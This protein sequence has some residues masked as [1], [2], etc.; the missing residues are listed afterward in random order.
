MSWADSNADHRFNFG[1]DMGTL[2]VMVKDS[3]GS[4]Q[5]IVFSDPSIFTNTMYIQPENGNNR[6]FIRNLTANN[7]PL[8]ID[9]MNSRTADAKGL[10]GIL[11]VVR[12]TEIIEIIIF[13]LLMLAAAW[14]W[15]KKA[16]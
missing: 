2:P 15:K 9:Q 12:N 16:I 13:C 10:S 4:G 14:A 1:E 3:V 6:D 11:H 7:G 5:L 8:L